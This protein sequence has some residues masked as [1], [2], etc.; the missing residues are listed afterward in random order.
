MEQLFALIP[1][2]PLSNRAGQ[3]INP[4]LRCGLARHRAL[5]HFGGHN[6]VVP[7]PE[8]PQIHRGIS[9]IVRIRARGKSE[10]QGNYGKDAQHDRA[11]RENW[12]FE[13]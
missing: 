2:E 8:A 12:F 9:Q 11:L 5:D 13:G 6:N 1:V 4:L 7:Q 3:R 10:Q